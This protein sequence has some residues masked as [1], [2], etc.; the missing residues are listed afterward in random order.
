MNE[1]QTRYGSFLF[2]RFDG[3]ED[4]PVGGVQVASINE[5]KSITACCIC[6]LESVSRNL[7]IDD[8]RG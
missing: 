4:C 6:S 3:K 8:G 7:G 2:I 5:F 1:M